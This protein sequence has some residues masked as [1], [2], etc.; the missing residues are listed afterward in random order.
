MLISVKYNYVFLCTP[1]C[2]SHSIEAMLKPYSDI[3]F[4]NMPVLRHTNYVEYAHYIKPYLDAK[5]GSNQIETIC[6]IREP[7]SWLNS[8][9]RFRLRNALRNPKHPSHKNSTYGVEFSEF[10]QAYMSPNPP[11]YANVSS[12]FGFVRDQNHQVGIDTIFRY[13]NIEDFV[14]YMS[15]R[16]GKKLRITNLNT[17]PKKVYKSDIA[18]WA[19]QIKRGLDNKLN[20]S[21]SFPVTPKVTYDVSEDLLCS[22]RQFM[23]NDFELYEILGSA[24]KY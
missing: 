14:E 24:N 10:I 7:V 13:E 4:L 12:Q 23:S 1:K 22:L 16:I 8:W 5:F 11:S 15:Q 9:Y 3:A 19:S 2:A 17:S 6:L 18:S 21:S 20:L